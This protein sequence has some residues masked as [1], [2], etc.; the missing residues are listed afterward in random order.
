MIGRIALTMGLLAAAM[1]AQADQPGFDIAEC[2]KI[3]T[4]RPVL[5][6][7]V[8]E[9]FAGTTEGVGKSDGILEERNIVQLELEGSRIVDI[10]RSVKTLQKRDGEWAQSHSG[11]DATTV[12]YGWL[13]GSLDLMVVAAAKQNTPG[14]T[15]HYARRV[16]HIVQ[17][18]PHGTRI[19]LTRQGL[20][21]GATRH[22]RDNGLANYHFVYDPERNELT[23][24]VRRWAWPMSDTPAPLF[25]MT[26]QTDDEDVDRAYVARIRERVVHRMRYMDGELCDGPIELFYTVQPSDT[27]GQIAEHYL[28]PL[29]PADVIEQANPRLQR[30]AEGRLE[31]G[32]E[33]RIPVPADW[34]R[35]RYFG[36]AGGA[37]ME[38]CH[39]V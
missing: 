35:R 10:G 37:S 19:L 29:A 39:D 8:K 14:G 36:Q 28:G 23:E 30:D 12:V 6:V 1:S 33:L 24:T 25:H 16:Y 11:I 18:G 27:L 31:A 5:C 7:G 20:V 2:A 21:G 32:V 26:E 17:H 3:N 15:G 4:D 38:L 13:A 9:K 22:V 34:L